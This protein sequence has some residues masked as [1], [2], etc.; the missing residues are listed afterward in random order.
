MGKIWGRW[1]FATGLP[2]PEI[3]EGVA[4]SP[5]VIYVDIHFAHIDRSVSNLC[6]WSIV[7][8]KKKLW[9]MLPW[10]VLLSWKHINKYI[11]WR[12]IISPLLDCRFP[13]LP[14]DGWYFT[15]PV[16]SAVSA[17]P[18]AGNSTHASF[19]KT[20]KLVSMNFCFS[21]PIPLGKKKHVL[22]N[23]IRIEYFSCC[24][25][26]GLLLTNTDAIRVLAEFLFIILCS[27]NQMVYA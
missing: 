19:Q 3:G 9:E 13:G 16:W 6:S 1:K 2:Y 24:V 23:T 5:D 17:R 22:S 27:G 10:K 26:A 7:M 4:V 15:M 21:S 18:P 12:E 14:S 25:S 11:K 8:R 20:P